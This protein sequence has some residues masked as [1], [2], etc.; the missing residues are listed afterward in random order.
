MD[1]GFVIV[2]LTLGFVV[3]SIGGG[4]VA[5]RRALARWRAARVVRAPVH[6]QGTVAATA[7]ALIFGLMGLIVVPGIA[8]HLDAI[9]VVSAVMIG[10]M[11]GVYVS[12]SAPWTVIG[13]M[14][15]DDDALTYSRRAEPE[16]RVALDEPWELVQGW[17]ESGSNI[18]IV[19]G[20]RQVAGQDVFFHYRMPLVGRTFEVPQGPP[21]PVLGPGLGAAAQVMHERL[22]AAK[23]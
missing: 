13:E 1:P 21:R 11:I 4:W 23:V 3:V 5:K 8:L 22:R 18:F 2:S 7:I 20:A 17:G 12:I 19:V 16:L 6:S 9:V 15:L 14:V 10:A